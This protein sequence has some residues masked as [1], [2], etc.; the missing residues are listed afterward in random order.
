M[1]VLCLFTYLYCII[2]QVTILAR[3]IEA[4]YIDDSQAGSTASG[5]GNNSLTMTRLTQTS[6]NPTYATSFREATRV[7]ET[8][9]TTRSK[10]MVEARQ[11]YAILTTTP[12]ADTSPSLELRNLRATS[13]STPKPQST[14]RKTYKNNAPAGDL[15]ASCLYYNGS[16]LPKR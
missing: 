7:E 12:P 5:S 10:G 1:A 16:S 4:S 11:I 3:T 14:P 15:A 8:R 2:L 13:V 6:F 9:T